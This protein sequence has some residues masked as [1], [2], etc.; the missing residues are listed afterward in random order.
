MLFVVLVVCFGFRLLDLLA[1]V[2]VLVGFVTGV[3]C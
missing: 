3:D 2:A 1:Y